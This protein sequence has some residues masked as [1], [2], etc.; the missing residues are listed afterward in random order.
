MPIGSC[1]L[2]PETPV[3]MG[4]AVLS[5][6]L[7]VIIGPTEVEGTNGGFPYVTIR[8]ATDEDSESVPTGSTV[9]VVSRG[10]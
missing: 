3:P 4:A 2:P 8:S 10:G 1:R 7:P 5:L 9:S 6:G